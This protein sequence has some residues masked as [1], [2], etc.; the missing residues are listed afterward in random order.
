MAK[1]TEAAPVDYY[2]ED[3]VNTEAPIIGHFYAKIIER[4]HVPIHAGGS[5]T[6]GQFVDK[7]LAE[8]AKNKVEVM[9]ITVELPQED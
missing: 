3:A 9:S 5:G 2:G 1:Y 4:V 7:Q 8:M 6:I